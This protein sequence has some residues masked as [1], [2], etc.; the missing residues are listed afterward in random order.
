MG[1][2]SFV[3]AI[4]TTCYSLLISFLAAA[5]VI[6]DGP[7]SSSTGVG[8]WA[9]FN[10]TVACT[11]TVDWYAEGYDGDITESCTGMVGGMMICREIVQTCT[12]PTST[13]LTETLR[14]LAS[15]MHAGTSI[16]VQCAAFARNFVISNCPPNLSYSRYALLTS[17]C[18]R[19]PT[20][21]SQ[22]LIKMCGLFVCM[23][24]Q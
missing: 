18:G 9:E 8:E 11:H 20:P 12:A 7:R 6:I 16:A 17:K 4:R 15:E 2:G 23:F 22:Q 3:L 5:N 13:G 19:D 14:I 21:F 10:C 1:L 24:L